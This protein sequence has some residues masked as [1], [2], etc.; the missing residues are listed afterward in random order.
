MTIHAGHPF[1][2]PD[3]TGRDQA[4]RLRAR[5]GSAVS[6]WA[7]GRLDGDAAGLTVSSYLV[8]AG[9]PGRIV[10]ALDPDGDL[11]ERL[12]S[13]GRA[14]VHLLDGSRRELAEMFGG[15]M[16]APGGV[17]AQAG[18][19]QT[20]HGPRLEDARTWALVSCEREQETGWS[21]LVTVTI[22]EVVIGEQDWLV[23]R[24]GRY[25]R[26]AP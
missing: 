8:V 13:S 14:V 10:A 23:H 7:A 15:T 26:V 5:V 16:P 1:A 17:F 21:T 2:D 24:Q 4:R 3:D 9:E 22:D 11:L 25:H 18:F 12:R 6:L 20:P 19:V